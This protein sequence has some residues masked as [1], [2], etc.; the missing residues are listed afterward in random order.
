MKFIKKEFRES[1]KHGGANV[2]TFEMGIKEIELL[3]AVCI[4]AYSGT[5]RVLETIPTIGRLGNFLKTLGRVIK[6]EQQ[7][8]K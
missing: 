6:N 1:K 3:K 7:S 8:D 5:P 2:Y 4:K